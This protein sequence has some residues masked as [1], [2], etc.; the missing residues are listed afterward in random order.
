MCGGI[1]WVVWVDSG[2]L[3]KTIKMR[4]RLV[5]FGFSVDGL[6]CQQKRTSSLTL[7]QENFSGTSVCH[8]P[9]CCSFVFMGKAGEDIKAFLWRR[10]SLAEPPPALIWR[11]SG[12]IMATMARSLALSAEAAST[13]LHSTVLP[14]H[15]ALTKQASQSSCFVCLGD[16]SQPPHPHTPTCAIVCVETCHLKSKAKARKRKVG[17]E[18]SLK[19]FVS[20]AW[21]LCLWGTQVRRCFTFL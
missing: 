13:V 17:F 12:P 21:T 19:E 2:C 16:E 14:L 6:S 15:R 1:A 18:W 20:K 5:G 8:S 11:E 4:K 9:S 7:F 3:K 10:I